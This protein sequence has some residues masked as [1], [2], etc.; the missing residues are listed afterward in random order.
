MTKAKKP[1][2]PSISGGRITI[3]KKNKNAESSLYAVRTKYADMLDDF[4][5]LCSASHTDRNIVFS[6]YVTK[7]M[8]RVEVKSG[9]LGFLLGKTKRVYLTS[10]ERGMHMYEHQ[11]NLTHEYGY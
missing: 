5:A 9:E 11:H 10:I 3:L 7:I 4:Q 6:Q 2:D 1:Y 8:K